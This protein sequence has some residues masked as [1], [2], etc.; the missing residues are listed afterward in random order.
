MLFSRFNILQLESNLQLSKKFPSV[1]FSSNGGSFARE[2][3]PNF[4]LVSARVERAFSVRFARQTKRRGGRH[5]FLSSGDYSWSD[6]IF[7]FRGPVLPC[8]PNKEARTSGHTRRYV[9]TT[10]ERKTRG[11]PA[12]RSR[13]RRRNNA[14]S[15]RREN[16]RARDRQDETRSLRAARVSFRTTDNK[17]DSGDRWTWWNVSTRPEAGRQTNEAGIL[18]FITGPERFTSRKPLLI[19]RSRFFFFLLDQQTSG[20]SPLLQAPPAGS[21]TS[22]S[23]CCAKKSRVPAGYSRPSPFPIT[24]RHIHAE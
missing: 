20:V 3:S 14:C 12:R 7:F 9:Q 24:K 10:G 13:R 4:Q 16:E 21:S 19:G 11:G 18:S 15:R 5:G 8:K 23:V 22:F 17:K 1:R 6:D 2:I